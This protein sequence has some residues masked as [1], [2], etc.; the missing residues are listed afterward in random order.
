MNAKHFK[1]FKEVAEKKFKEKVNGV[2][3]GPPAHI[4][5]DVDNIIE[6][7]K[8]K[9]EKKGPGVISEFWGMDLTDRQ[10]VEVRMMLYK[11]TFEQL[12]KQEKE[13]CC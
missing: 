1:K 10:Y 6:K 4:R 8:I 12:I 5:A 9:N 2:I 11:K 7:I 3:G 13:W